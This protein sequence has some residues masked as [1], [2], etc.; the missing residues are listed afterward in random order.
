MKMNE[1]ELKADLAKKREEIKTFE[2]LT[3]F[4]KYVKDNC[5]YGYGGAPRAIAQASLA[6]AWYLAGEFGITGFQA[7][8]VM[9]D[10]ICDWTYSNN[11]CGLKIVNYDDMLYPQYRYKYE[12]TIPSHVWESLKKEVTE[13]L[14]DC[15]YCH[16]D[17][18]AHWK[19]IANGNVP[20]EYIV[21][22]D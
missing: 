1:F 5:N 12:K 2:E 21:K 11:K 22:E 18:I 14:K 7:G 10:F 19:S 3:E 9:W 15:E 16:P 8:C 20:F 13:R 6:V 4:L 17:V